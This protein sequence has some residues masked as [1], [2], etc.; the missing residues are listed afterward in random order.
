MRIGVNGFFHS[1][2]ST[3]SGAYLRNLFSAI[4]H[5][6]SADDIVLVV[7]ED[8][9]TGPGIKKLDATSLDATSLD[10]TSLDATSGASSRLFQYPESVALARWSEN[11]GKVWFEQVA[12]GQACRREHVAL[13]HVPYF[14]S[15]LFP[16]APTVV[17]IHDLIPLLLPLYR[18]SWL[19]RL[20][21]RLVSVSARRAQRVIADSECSK[22]DI[23][24]HLGIP[25]ERIRVVYLA[26]GERYRPAAP[27][28]VQAVRAKYALPE[29]YLLYLGGFDQRKNVRVLIEA[30]ALLPELASA[31]WTLALAGATGGRDSAFFP[32]PERMARE[33]GVAERAIRMIGWVSE[34][35]KPALYT[36]AGAF[37][38]PSLY[39]GFGLPPLEA[40]ACGAP[41]ICSNAGSLPEIVG[42][43]ALQAE[44]TSAVAWAE[45]IR[46][47]CTDPE[48]RR[49]LRERGP[50]QAGQFSWT[51]A[52]S[53]TASLYRS[54]LG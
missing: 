6:C 8:E 31:G 2:P 26:A 37:L 36:G 34:E 44:P 18:G 22:R 25:E 50:A 10:A 39:E 29:N 15:P 11:L 51:R 1:Q 23:V 45:S 47:V 7:P 13:A 3:G 49:E 42:S 17:T 19:V 4:S 40:M 12:F 53:E 41:V 27:E 9:F 43:A 33:T 21:T 28:Q 16:T 35:D 48:R 32:D 24:K 14:A 20:Y 38:F 46:A 54:V 30:L 5:E 52:A